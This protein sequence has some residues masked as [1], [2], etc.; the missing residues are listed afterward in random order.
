MLARWR[1]KPIGMMPQEHQ[2][3]TGWAQSINLET[4]LS[5]GYGRA[6][7]KFSRGELMNS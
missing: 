6:L 3:I 2:P 1:S 4:R 7:I 5:I